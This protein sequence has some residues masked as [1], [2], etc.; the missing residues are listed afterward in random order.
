[1]SETPEPE[2]CLFLERIVDVASAD[3]LAFELLYF[4]PKVFDTQDGPLA[5]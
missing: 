2:P 5:V 4:F 3:F 1:M